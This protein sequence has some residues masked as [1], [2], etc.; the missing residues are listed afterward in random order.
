MDSIPVQIIS[1]APQKREADFG[2]AAYVDTIADLIAFEEN[3][4]P[5]VIGVYGKWGS[6][7]TTL[8]KSIA[9]KLDTDEKYQGGTPYRNSKTV[10]FQAWK[11]KDEDEILA[12]LIE[13]IFKAMAKD[14]FFTGCRAQIEKL[15]EG[16]N[17]PKLFTS[18]IKKITTLDISEFFQDPAYKKFTGF[19]DV[20]EDFFTRLI[21]TYLSWRPQKNQCETHGE[22]K[23]VLAVFIDDLDRCPREKIVSVL[24]TLKLFMD[25]KGCVFII[26]ADNDIII[27]ALE[28]TYHGDAER[29]MDKIVQVTFNLP[30]IPT[31]DFAPFLKKIGN[32]FGKGIET[33]LPLV[34]PA[35]ENNPRNIKRFINDLNLLK[36]LVA[37]KGI[38]I[39]PE[40][41]LL[42]NVIEKG[43]RPF[44]LA[45]KEQGGFNTLSAMHE[46]IDTAR[47]KNIELPAM[48]EDDSLAIPDSL[49]SYFREMTLVRIVDSFRPEKKGLKQLVT[50]AR[51]VETPKKEE[52]RKG[53]RPGEDK[54]VL[55]PAG[56]FIYQENQTQRLNYDYEMD[57]YPVTNHRFDRFVKAGGYGKKDFWD[58]KGWQWRETKHIDQPQYWEDKA[59]NDPEQPVVGV[60]WYE[61]DAY[62]RWMTKFRDDGYTC[63]LPDEV[64]WERAAR[65]D[66]GNV[67]P[68]G[69]TFDPDKCNSAESNIGKPSRVSVY[70]N[71]V[72]PYGCYDMAGNVW[73][74][75]S[76]FYDNKE[77]RFFL[78]GGSFDGG[79]DY[80]R[81]AARSNYYDPGN[82]SFFI[83]FRCVRIKR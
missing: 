29:F 54:R 76:S 61:A 4:T 22:K 80:C 19:Y 78:R 9:H 73:E 13:Q 34:I 55:I 47:E 17:T 48:A 10:W 28:K 45:L 70:P 51:I 21:W 15:T 27:K 52:N 49:V 11:Y 7:K 50:L 2:F 56:T 74:W 3:Q 33:Y 71:G 69:N 42:W 36:G 30:K 60:S 8:M 53:Q 83:G 46:K 75:T 44:S 26:G 63:K 58:D 59:Y 5:L 57:L 64:E 1:D 37:N 35:M 18:L 40:D 67:Y 20:F 25:Q 72:S 6:G 14:G 82:R 81:C 41:L 77:N 39:L 16:I 23:G 32:E 43:F 68:W 65:G 66:G 31:E 12:A 24:E 62:A 38:D 79:S